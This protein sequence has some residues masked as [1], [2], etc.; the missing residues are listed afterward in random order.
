LPATFARL[1]EEVR[2]TATTVVSGFVYTLLQTL[3]A[4]FI[5]F[6]LVRDQEIVTATLRRLSPLTS[7]ETTALFHRLADT[8]HATILGT[9]V[10]ALLQGVLG[11]SIFW[12]LGLPMPALWGLAM[13]LLAIVPYLG[14]FVIWAPA[15]AILVLQGQWW[16]A[17]VLVI[18]GS[19]VIGLIDNLIYPIFVGNRLQQHTIVAFIAI[20]GG[21]AVFGA[22]GV[23]LGPIIISLTQF[24]VGL[25]RRR[26]RDGHAADGPTV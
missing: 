5:F 21:I 10:V 3:I 19:I 2:D 4:L 23:V 18:W 8:V 9:V 14:A 11:G 12:F 6:Y 22:T 20:I 13:G 24:L 1:L 25:W 16:Q 26:T 17:G 15:A 7:S